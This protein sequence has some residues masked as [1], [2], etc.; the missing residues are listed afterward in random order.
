M[1]LTIIIILTVLSLLSGAL[2]GALWAEISRAHRTSR[3][4]PR[5]KK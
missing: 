3:D 2:L 1:I 5:T 4:K